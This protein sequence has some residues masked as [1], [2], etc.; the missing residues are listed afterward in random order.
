MIGYLIGGIGDV[1]G[2]D[3]WLRPDERDAL[4]ALSHAKRRTDWRLG[5]WVAKQAVAAALAV[6]AEALEIRNDDDGAPF[7]VAGGEPLAL[8]ISLS[9]SSGVGLCTVA[10]PPFAIGCDVE[11]VEERAPVFE[12]D[13]FTAA[14]RRLV[15][16]APPEERDLRV[17]VIWSAKE[18]ALKAARAG[19]RRDTRSVVVEELDAQR[20]GDWRR[21]R[22]R[23]V[24]AAG[25]N[26]DGWWRRDGEMVISVAGASMPEPPSAL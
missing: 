4:A 24:Q 7:V 23:D 15:G 22:I 12:A 26:L 14:E 25:S 3:E 9:H 5:R 1:P 21:L 19:L 18:S 20:A 8:A 16:T 11:R 13:W 10:V 6:S 17:T 2:D